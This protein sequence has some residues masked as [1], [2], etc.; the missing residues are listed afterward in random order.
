MPKQ[1]TQDKQKQIGHMEKDYAFLK[2]HIKLSTANFIM[3]NY[4]AKDNYIL[5]LEIIMQVNSDLIKKKAE[6]HI[7]GQESNLMCIKESLK[8]ENVMEEE[9]FGGQMEVGMKAIS[10]MG[11][12]VDSEYYIDKVEINNIRE[13]G[14]M[15]CSMVKEFNTS[16]TVKDIKVVSNRT[17]SMEMVYFTKMIQ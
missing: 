12:K 13:F 16:T 11:C 7:I 6:A 3:D 15:V 17:S 9:R 4:K 2:T 1:Y 14:T 5:L 8:E 10:K